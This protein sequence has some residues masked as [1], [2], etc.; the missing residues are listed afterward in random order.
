MCPEVCPPP[1]PS[2]APRRIRLLVRRSEG[3][4]SKDGQT[5]STWLLRGISLEEE[6]DGEE[7]RAVDEACCGLVLLGRG[8][9]WSLLFSQSGIMLVPGGHFPGKSEPRGLST[10]Q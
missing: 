7:S 8:S 4:G 9:V 3:L 5:L 2:L 10:S 1:L 6:E